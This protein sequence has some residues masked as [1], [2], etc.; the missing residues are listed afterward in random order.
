ML[1]GLGN[2][3]KL[4][5]DI[6]VDYE[7]WDI[8]TSYELLPVELP[9]DAEVEVVSQGALAAAIRITRTISKSTLTQLV[10]LRAHSERVDFD[11]TVDWQETHRMLKVGFD[12]D[13]L[14]PEAVHEIQYGY[15]RRP[16]HR[17][18][19]FD[20]DR[21]EVPNYRWTALCEEGRGAAVLNDCK[22]GINVLGSSINLTL[23]RSPF[24]PDPECDHGEQH[25]VYSF[26]PF[27]GSLRESGLTREAYDLNCPALQYAGAMAATSALS[28]AANN[29]FV[30]AI[31]P[32]ED[33]SD[34]YVLR[35]YESMG[36]RTET[37]LTLR[38]PAAAVS[39]CDMLEENGTPVEFAKTADGVE[40]ALQF[41][42]FEVKTLRVKP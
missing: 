10:T 40:I 33:G 3:M 16:T 11:T 4:F 31:K 37:T 28:V 1:R 34:D 20:F 19:P 25:F 2:E 17:S 23:L 12:V 6:T 22:Y 9:E 21:F 5:K 7:A 35:V 13:V 41:R 42:P 30:D 29:V 8:D 32:A 27:V 36:T 14:A 15:V 26:L 39:A 38:L 18:R 24:S